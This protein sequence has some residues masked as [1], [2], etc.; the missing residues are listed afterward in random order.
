M[1][2]NY[3]L[4]ASARNYDHTPQQWRAETRLAEARIS[5]EALCTSYAWGRHG[6]WDLKVALGY[7]YDGEYELRDGGYVQSDPFGLA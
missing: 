1:R 7:N 2:C 4:V 3:D 5:T 6:A